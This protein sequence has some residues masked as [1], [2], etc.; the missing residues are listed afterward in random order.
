MI[1][2]VLI[3]IACLVLVTGCAVFTSLPSCPTDDFYAY[4]SCA[5]PTYNTEG[6]ATPEETDETYRNIVETVTFYC[7]EPVTEWLPVLDR[8]VKKAFP[9]VQE[10]LEREEGYG[11][12]DP[13]YYNAEGL[14]LEAMEEEQLYSA[15]VSIFLFAP[16]NHG[17]R[18]LIDL[19]R[20][21]PD[22]ECLNTS[23]ISCRN[24]KNDSCVRHFEFLEDGGVIKLL[25]WD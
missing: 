19:Y 23:P 24:P 7:A 1:A 11:R 21:D 4:L 25:R 9:Q 15:V 22:A 2:R 20:E 6:F 16:V 3:P 13:T 5:K 10:F 17:M 8:T 12:F 14:E 18:R